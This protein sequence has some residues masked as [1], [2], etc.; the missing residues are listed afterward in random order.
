MDTVFF[1]FS[2]GSYSS[3]VSVSRG[4]FFFKVF[5]E[6]YRQVN[7]NMRPAMRHLFGTWLTVFPAPVL[8]KIEEQLQFSPSANHQSSNLPSLKASES[9]R[10]IH[11]IHVNPKYLEARR[12]LEQS[13]VD[14]VSFLMQSPFRWECCSLV[15]ISYKLYLYLALVFI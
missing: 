1:L 10:P 6:A 9:P 8:R 5:C 14:S 7:A 11:G 4:L 2:D 12:Q 13:T 3:I 15:H